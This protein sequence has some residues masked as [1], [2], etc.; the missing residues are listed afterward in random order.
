M[1][2]HYYLACEDDG[3][4][5]DREIKDSNLGPFERDYLDALCFIFKGA[6]IKRET[7]KSYT[8]N[9]SDPILGT[10]FLKKKPNILQAS[11]YFQAYQKS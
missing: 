7:D 1:D 6:R 10:R 9:Y 5:T 11:E 4:F 2:I 8:Y 3:S